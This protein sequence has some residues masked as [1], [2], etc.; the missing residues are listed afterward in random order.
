MLQQDRTVDDRR[1]TREGVGGGQG[2][3][4]VAD[5]GEAAGKAFA[6]AAGGGAVAERAGEL[7]VVAVG[8]QQDGPD[9][10]ETARDRARSGGDVGG[11]TGRPADGAALDDETVGVGAVAGRDAGREHLEGAA[12]VQD[13]AALESIRTREGHRGADDVDARVVAAGDVG[14]VVE[15]AAAAAEAEEAG[16]ARRVDAGVGDVTH[17]GAERHAGEIEAALAE[18]DRRR[19]VG[20]RHGDRAGARG[21]GEAVDLG[22]RVRGV[23]HDGAALGDHEEAAGLVAVEGRR[24]EGAAGAD[25]H[26][27]RVDRKLGV[28]GVDAGERQR[29]L[30]CLDQSAG[31]VGRSEGRDG[32]GRAGAAAAREGDGRDGTRLVSTRAGD[33]DAGDLAV[34]DDRV[35][36]G[37]SAARHEARG[38]ED[39][40]RGAD[41]A[42]SAR[43]GHVGLREARARGGG[44]A[45][46]GDGET[47]RVDGGDAR[48]RSGARDGRI[49]DRPVK[50]VGPETV[51][52]GDAVVRGDVRAAADALERGQDAGGHRGVGT[53][54]TAREVAVAEVAPAVG[55]VDR[56]VVAQHHRARQL[57]VEGGGAG[58]R[59]V[60]PAQAAVA[61]VEDAAG[62]VEGAVRA[63]AVEHE[64]DFARG[65]LT[66]DEAAR[67]DGELAEAVVTDDEPVA[68]EV[69]IIEDARAADVTD[70]DGGGV[71]LIE[72]ETVDARSRRHLEEAA[73]EVEVAVTVEG[74]ALVAV[75]ARGEETHRAG[76]LVVDGDGADGVGALHREQ[77]DVA[78]DVDDALIGAVPVEEV[79]GGDRAHVGAGDVQR[80]A[81]D[82]RVAG[83]GVG[84]R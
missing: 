48:T 60:A 17:A 71:V 43:D 24:V 2:K 76:R 32:D 63:G 37:R 19:G 33:D 41:V 18:V 49:I 42:G 34:G 23:R 82:G 84:A 1:V 77:V 15:D 56:G 64:A 14:G 13:E 10:G 59:A 39:D 81:V 74:H 72:V 6:G 80:A 28:E 79:R 73:G 20:R 45:G 8:V 51:R 5:L 55:H 12:G 62:D 31:G 4:A 11:R 50:G 27:A 7:D 69:G 67:T 58:D 3:H 65:V 61:A 35:T 44:E 36:G 26:G 25:G 70:A 46:Q 54:G 40:G 75:A 38:A 52:S 22:E 47:V 53:E 66:V 21:V 83:V 9:E 68:R 30:P 57:V 78:A 29:A 16:H